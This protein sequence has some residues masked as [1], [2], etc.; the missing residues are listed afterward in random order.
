MSTSKLIG[1]LL[2]HGGSLSHIE[3]RLIFTLADY[4]SGDGS[5]MFRANVQDLAARCRMHPSEVRDA[6]S[7][8]HSRPIQYDVQF[9][10]DVETFG[11]VLQ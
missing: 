7:L 10:Y 11:V 4:C 2:K 1:V 6:I 3:H 9:L 8:L 5:G